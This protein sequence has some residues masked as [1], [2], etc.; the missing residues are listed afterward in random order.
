MGLEV[1]DRGL[2]KGI[3]MLPEGEVAQVFA[4]RALGWGM[5]R[6]G[7]ELGIARNTVRDWLREGEGREYGGER[8][9]S[10]QARYYFWI[11]SRFQGGVRNADVLRQE[12]E[13]MDISVSL[14]TV[15][16]ALRP[17]RE[18]WERAEKATMRFETAPGKQLQVDFGEKWLLIEGER[19][20]RY[21]FVATLGYSRRC[22]VE[23]FGSLRQRDWIVGLERAFHHFGGVPEEL[24][25][26]N[27]KPLVNQHPTG[28]KAVFHPEFEAFCRHWGVVPRAC[29]P[30]RARTK[31]KVENGVGYVKKNA[32]GGLEFVSE[33]A[34]DE[35]LASWMRNVADVRIHGTT[36]ERPIDRFEAEKG[37]LRPV[38]NHPGYLRV[39]NFTRKVSTDFRIDV[40]TNRYSVPSAFVGQTLDV[41]IEADTLRVVFQDR[42]VAEHTV[43]P[44]HHQVIEDPGHVVGFVEGRKQLRKAGEIHRPL[45]DYAVAAGGGEW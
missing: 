21:V 33:E 39:R 34:L 3:A 6:I 2:R 7:R 13:T 29:Q 23:V 25:T 43:H 8:R 9:V 12:L 15:E 20:K 22:Y 35:H 45:S 5:R 38:L 32:L 41:V 18:S 28:G 19:Q 10:F 14:R 27:A 40:D 31:G 16:R 1:L 42:I 44:G 11:Q 4:L 37:A 36:H 24:L 17:F 26:D 30:F